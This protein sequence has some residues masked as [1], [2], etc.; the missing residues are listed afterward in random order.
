MGLSRYIYATESCKANVLHY[1]FSSCSSVWHPVYCSIICSI[2]EYACPVWHPGLTKK[3][4]KDVKWVQKRCLKLLYPLFSHTEALRKS[5]LDRLDTII[6]VLLCLKHKVKWFTEFNKVSSILIQHIVA[7]V[8]SV[9]TL[10]RQALQ[11][12]SMH[13]AQVVAHIYQWHITTPT[14]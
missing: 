8:N 13:T 3:L 7:S 5:G 1:L 11:L 12:Q 9:N 10:C 2:L 6:C 4:F 14:W